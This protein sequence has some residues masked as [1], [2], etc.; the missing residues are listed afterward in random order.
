MLDVSL[1]PDILIQQRVPVILL[2]ILIQTMD[3]QTENGSWDEQPEVTA[4]AIFTLGETLKLPWIHSIKPEVIQ[5]LARGRVYLERHDK[6]NGNGYDVQVT[7]VKNSS[8]IFFP[9]R[10]AA[11][12]MNEFDQIPTLGRKTSKLLCVQSSQARKFKNFFS[13]VPAFI[14]EPSWKLE[15]WILQ[16]F[17]FV[18]ELSRVRLEIFPRKNVSED[19]YLQYIPFTWIS[20]SNGGSKMNLETQWEMMWVSLLMYQADEYMEAVVGQ[21]F[22]HDLEWVKELVRKCCSPST[23]KP[24]HKR[25]FNE[26]EISEMESNEMSLT[27]TDGR[28]VLAQK[29]EGSR[30][31][32]EE[33]FTGFI[34]HVRQ[35]PKVFSSSKWLQVWLA[36]EIEKFPLA[37][38][39]HL[40]DCLLFSKEAEGSN[41]PTIFSSARVSYFDWVRTTSSDTT[42]CPFAFVLFLC[43]IHE[44]SKETLASGLPRYVV[45]SACRHLATMCRQHNDI[46]SVHRDYAEKNLNSINFSELIDGLE[47]ADDS[48]LYQKQAALRKELLKISEFERKELDRDLGELDKLVDAKIMALLRV[49]VKVTDLYGQ[50]YLI[51]DIGV[52]KIARDSK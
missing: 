14:N 42:S 10:Q 8:N 25:N 20:C 48:D 33:V 26:M 23:E 35:H 30:K 39:K 13:R 41:Q 52:T 32:V 5:S 49:F 21:E 22:W 17:Q 3:R 7:E 36:K 2:D 51:R 6:S 38:I 4:C 37:H 31:E 28:F 40:E 27:R 47:D 15:L 43:C 34:F 12:K 29:N 46:G 9:L 24:T 44:P 45:Q 18:P 50:I 11:L 19:K 1:V 16:A